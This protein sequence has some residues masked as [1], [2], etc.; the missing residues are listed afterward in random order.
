MEP[1]PFVLRTPYPSRTTWP[2]ALDE[3][4]TSATIA[5]ARRVPGAPSL[6][7][8]RDAIEDVACID[9]S[10]GRNWF[11][12]CFLDA[13]EGLEI[14][15]DATQSDDCDRGWYLAGAI[16]ALAGRHTGARS[17]VLLDHFPGEVSALL[18][19]RHEACGETVRPRFDM[20]CQT[21][22][23]AEAIRALV[24]KAVCKGG[25][26]LFERLLEEAWSLLAAS[27]VGDASS[28]AGLL[29]CAIDDLR[30]HDARTRAGFA[31]EVAILRASAHQLRGEFDRAAEI[32][33]LVACS[34][35][36][37]LASQAHV[38]LGLVACRI[39]PLA[40]VA[41]P[42]SAGEFLSTARRLAPGREH[43]ALGATR[44]NCRRAE[45]AYVLGVVF[46]ASGA[47]ECTLV[48]LERAVSSPSERDAVAGDHAI[49][50]RA[51][52]DLAL[53]L[54]ETSDASRAE[55]ALVQLEMAVTSLGTVPTYLLS[56]TLAALAS[57]R[58]DLSH[59]APSARRPWVGDRLDEA[60][61]RR[62]TRNEHETLRERPVDPAGEIQCWEMNMPE[63]LP[64]EGLGY[65]V[66]GVQVEHRDDVTW[67]PV[68]RA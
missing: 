8:M 30:Q 32:L 29:E 58:A 15:F 39:R 60:M 6:E 31:H 43:V 50:P 44:D 51:Q 49:R 41:L 68:P 57:T 37:P 23:I 38:D 21:G 61:A 24:A 52:R 28:I 25:P 20:C 54:A 16:H 13:L 45:A 66:P 48:P 3:L 40:D 12:L 26:P 9:A 27:C 17:V 33:G 59:R 11:H 53:A 55:E 42:A 63:P 22:R 35:I 18:G 62:S 65:W 2:T 56:R 10:R 14:D 1:H 4:L 19:D 46:I 64:F 7:R 67:I 47:V 36:G 5:S 34:G